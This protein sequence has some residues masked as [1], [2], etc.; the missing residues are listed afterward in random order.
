MHIQNI[1]H[2][3]RYWIGLA[4]LMIGVL[5]ADITP[6]A[7]QFIESPGSMISIVWS[8]DGSRIAGGGY[9]GVIRVWDTSGNTLLTIGSLTSDIY[10]V[11]WSPDSTRLATG[12]ADRT[13]RIW[14]ATTGQLLAT[15][16][17][18]DEAITGLSWSPNGTVLA[19]AALRV[20]NALRVWNG[21]TYQ[22]LNARETGAIFEL[23]WSPDSTRFA[24]AQDNDY[25]VIYSA[26]LT[27]E[28]PILVGGAIITIHW[29]SDG[30]K[31]VMGK[32]DGQVEVWDA[33]TLTRLTAFQ[34]SQGYVSG[35]GVV[36]YSPN[37]QYIAT[38]ISTLGLIRV[39]DA[40]TYQLVVSFSRPQITATSIAWSPDGTRIAFGSTDGQVRIEPVFDRADDT[41]VQ[42]GD[43]YAVAWSPDGTRIVG[44]G[45]NGLL[46]IW[47]SSGQAVQD[48]PG[49][50]SWMRTVTWS[51]D[52][53]KIASGDDTGKI[54]IW[55]ASTGQ[56]LTTFI[57]HDD[58]VQSIAWSPDG[59]RIVTTSYYD[60][61]NLKL[62]DAVHYQMIGEIGTSE[63][64]D[65]RFSP[66]GLSV[67]AV[68][69]GGIV[70]KY[71]IPSLTNS[72]NSSV[73]P[74]TALLSVAWNSTG[75][76]I[77]TSDSVSRAI[78]WDAE[79]LTQ[80][81]TIDGHTQTVDAVVFSPSGQAIATASRDGTVRIWDVETGGQISSFP[82]PNIFTTAIAW[83]PDGT[84]IA[85]G[86]TDGQVRIEPVFDRAEDTR[87]QD[88]DVYAVAWS[89]DGTALAVGRG[90]HSID[91]L[92]TRGNVQLTLLGHTDY[93]TDLDWS[94]DGQWIVSGSG[95]RTAR[96]WNAFTGEL[97]RTIL[98]SEIANSVV[99]AIAW[100][101]DNVRFATGTADG[102]FRIW[103]SSTG[104]LLGFESVDER[105]VTDVSWS[106]DG[107]KLLAVS[108]RGR[109]VIWDTDVD[110]IIQVFEVESWLEGV[111]WSRDGSQVAVGS[112]DDQIYIW[113]IYSG[114]LIRTLSLPVGG[115]SPLALDW[116]ADG[117]FIVSP[118]SN[119]T[120]SM[121]LIWD[122]NT[123]SIL[124][125]IRLQNRVMDLELSPDDQYIAYATLNGS[126]PAIVPATPDTL[127]GT[128]IYSWDKDVYLKELGS[129]QPIRLTTNAEAGNV[130]W[131]PDGTRFAF[132]ASRTP[133]TADIYIRNSDGS[134]EVQ[135]TQN[136]RVSDLAWSPDG[137]R[138][139]FRSDHEI[140]VININGSNLI[141]VS[142]HP[143]LDSTPTWS[144]DSQHISFASGRNGSS[145]LF[146]ANLGNGSIAQLTN[147]PNSS[148]VFP[149]WSPDG[150]RI[151][152]IRSPESAACE[153]VM[154]IDVVTAQESQLSDEICD[155]AQVK[156]LPDSQELLVLDN[157]LL[158]RLRSNRVLEQ[159]AYLYPGGGP[160]SVEQFDFM[161]GINPL[162]NGYGE[163]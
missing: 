1:L 140:Y 50:S 133:S 49:Y 60:V 16:P 43:V 4:A 17:I 90:D 85:F 19:S 20:S 160:I 148:N 124:G 157:S 154:S 80:I 109:A 15:L 44:G 77:A 68:G 57:A 126:V 81:S 142:N 24:V 94:N 71:S 115:M 40:N 163:G 37:G 123:G 82:K 147:S 95:D 116:S 12:G 42:D 14:N 112:K 137:T 161:P 139:G 74:N 128:I 136:M 58:V 107:S 91:I 102:A 25:V 97:V 76:Q 21:T 78:I 34:V 8:P 118:Y 9:G 159:L 100:N 86:S 120:E 105:E 145:E 65:A 121:I 156:W 51:P 125:T 104:Q 113:N 52:S 66:D 48:F 3:Q 132:V 6:T 110:Y 22:Q 119:D 150:S 151:A 122:S 61:R 11:A 56:L 29:N 141:N 41:G 38:S 69:L 18:Q 111:D 62:W 5:L 70:A 152:F 35:I 32:G 84:R 101:P 130:S 98:M 99:L 144:P 64:F 87:A 131:S 155:V 10:K 2:W 103:N 106:P 54:R 143:S 28:T 63:L 73:L 47:D 53:T 55:N 162:A 127:V 129:A 114:Q 135:I 93:L 23:N 134:G 31:L 45:E 117:T 89:P 92:D 59:T 88:G 153:V 13:I 75:S 26:D 72:L 33:N 158:Y 138:I 30:S 46:R 108:L 96:I 149:S 67:A 27:T 83:S 146:I 79:N 7:G 36:R 39:W